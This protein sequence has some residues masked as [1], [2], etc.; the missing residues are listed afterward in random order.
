MGGATVQ[1]FRRAAAAAV[2]AGADGVEVH[3]ANGYLVHQFLSSNANLREDQYGGSVQDRARFAIEVAAAVA[4]EIGPERT[5]IRIAPG[6]PFNDV[7]E[8]EVPAL[9]AA[10]VAGLAPLG[11]AY[12]HVVASGDEEPLRAIRR[13]WPGVLLLN[14]GGADMAAREADLASGLADVVTVGAMT[15]ANPDL[16]DRLRTGAPLNTPDRATFYGGGAAGY[17]DYPVLAAV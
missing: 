17:V 11:L 5:G 4:D 16:V 9:Y 6:N 1:D 13:D 2:E 8:E 15:L 7:R 12:L 3:G 14:R 10:L